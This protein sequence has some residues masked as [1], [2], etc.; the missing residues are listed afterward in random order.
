MTGMP[1]FV[2]TELVPILEATDRDQQPIDELAMSARLL[3]AIPPEREISP[4]ERKGAFAEIFAWRFQRARPDERRTWGIYW[5]EL[6]SWTTSEGRQIY[7]PDIADVDD[8]VVEHWIRRSENATHPTIRARFSD[9]AWEI[10]HH[11]KVGGQIPQQVAHRAVDEY[12]QAVARGL[13]SD[14]IDAWLWLDRASELAS[15][16]KDEARFLAARRA[17]FSLWKT[18]LSAGNTDSLWRLDDILWNY[19]FCPL[20]PVE[21]AEIVEALEDE[22]RR[23]S[24][25]ARPATFDPH[26]AMDMADRLRR[27]R[28]KGGEPEDAKRALSVAGT[29]FE[30]AAE[31]AD[32]LTAVS[33]LEDLLPRYRGV[34][35]LSAAA[36]VEQAIRT[37]SRDAAAEMK[38]ASVPVE[39]PAA[40]LEK[41]ADNVAGATIGEGLRHIAAAGLLKEGATR[42][43]VQEMLQGTALLA[44]IPVTLT[45]P[46]GLTKATVG[47]LKDDP[48]GRTLMHAA[49]LLGWRAPWLNLAFR[50]TREK[51]G[52]SVEGVI[53]HAQACPFFAADRM[54]LLQRGVE[55]WIAED[56][57][58]AVHILVPQIEAALRDCLAAV[59]GTVWRPNRTGG[60]KTLTLGDI[61]TDAVFKEKVSA[62]VRFHL[63]ALYTDARGLNVR[64]HFA[65]GLML[66][67][68][69]QRGLSNLVV[70]SVLLVAMLR[71]TAGTAG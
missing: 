34:G 18:L 52:I 63:R 25:I 23:R 8:D 36:R 2:P 20:L 30:D 51:H 40:E 42:S 69:F 15:T 24:D 71:P 66:P 29:A 62:D 7:S 61:L 38:T 27:W 3:A 11:Q 70:H 43:S 57:V 26:V 1:V 28:E 47:S 68:G 65:H 48:E 60:F 33:W 6:T 59:G 10:G 54:P 64:N 19:R 58:S 32:G 56:H 37:R 67:D 31:M 41:W 44:A 55:A 49:H 46:G 9:L 14:E 16:I 22:L 5:S 13:Y 17:A 12:L 35:D 45:G 39:I 21:R 4:D 50:R 53:A